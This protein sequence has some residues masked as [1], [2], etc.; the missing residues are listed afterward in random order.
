MNI[1]SDRTS[2][3]HPPGLAQCLGGANDGTLPQQSIWVKLL[4]SN[5]S[6]FAPKPWEYTHTPKENPHQRWT[7]FFIPRAELQRLWSAIVKRGGIGRDGEQGTSV[8]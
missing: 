2:Q 8:I 1:S 5:P 4:N 3:E 6:Q 7:D